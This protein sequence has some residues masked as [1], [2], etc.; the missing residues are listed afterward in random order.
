MIKVFKIVNIILFITCFSYFS[1]YSQNRN[2]YEKLK[3]SKKESLAYSKKLLN[4][5]KSSKEDNLNKLLITKE[6][7]YKQRQIL[8]IL[9]KELLLLDE[10]V[11]F[12]ENRLAS[13]QQETI[14]IKEEYAR[15]IQ[16]SYMNFNIQQR[17]IYILSAENF[18]KAYKRML[19]IKQLTDYRK[20][21]FLKIQE[22]INHTDSTINQLKTKKKE[23]IELLN[24]KSSSID[25]LNKIRHQLN[26]FINNTKNEMSNIFSQLESENQQ[27][28]ITKRNVKEQISIVE[29][30]K[31]E[32]NTKKSIT[33]DRDLNSKFEKNRRYHIWPLSKF[34]ILH[35]FGDYYHP[36]LE[37]IVVKNDGVEL[38]TKSGSN[39]HC[40][41][42]GKVI[43]IMA[44]PGNG[45]SVI[46]K[47][48]EFFSVYLNLDY[49]TVKPGDVL[50]KGQVI[51]R[52]GTG[53][54]VVRM[55]FQLW[56]GKEKLN[57]E[58]WLKKQ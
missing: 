2:Y 27:K 15:L 44:I 10:E 34:V 11:A 1:S 45:T 58:L 48:G 29:K 14:K 25:S 32:N 9:N 35:H 39:V 47:H 30:D 33:L 55:G 16:F 26:V 37:N 40:I 5:L 31:P 54:N 18:N 17:M 13:L 57:P 41:Y 8:N 52:L 42:D 28:E 51:G 43:N 23:K 56:K 36:V 3:K 6:Q 46:I 22:T 53:S 12:D 38:S 20:S 49:L 7:I 19:Y 4:E 50:E 21:R 24:E